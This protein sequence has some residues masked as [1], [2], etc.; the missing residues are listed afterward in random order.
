MLAD[1]AACSSFHTLR[2]DGKRAAA[3]HTLAHRCATHARTSFSAPCASNLHV[4][5]ELIVIKIGSMHAV[6]CMCLIYRALNSKFAFGFELQQH[7]YIS[8]K[9]PTLIT[10][11]YMA[12]V[13]A[14]SAIDRAAVQH[15]LYTRSS[16]HGT[17]AQRHRTSRSNPGGV[18]QSNKWLVITLGREGQGCQGASH[19]KG[20][21]G[22]RVQAASGDNRWTLQETEG[23]L[24]RVSACGCEHRSL[25]AQLPR[26]H[27]GVG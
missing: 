23:Q 22:G 25:E 17:C 4:L 18:K 3:Q 7:P 20:F 19:L 5:D 10:M 14:C 2:Q 1:C 13:V 11:L 24:Q 9:H 26:L 16:L 27:W 15:A 21:R 6:T 12:V 8:T